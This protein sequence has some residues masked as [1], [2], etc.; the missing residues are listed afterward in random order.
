MYASRSILAQTRLEQKADLTNF[1]TQAG[2]I[3]QEGSGFFSYQGLG[4]MALHHLEERLHQAMRAAGVVQWKMC[5]LQQQ[6]HW[7]KTGRDTQYGEELMSVRLRSGHTMRLTATAEEQVVASVLHHLKG[8]HNDFHLYQLGTK[9]RDEI[10]ARGGLLRGREFRMLDA[11]HFAQDE[12]MMMMRNSHM[13]DELVLF[14]QSLGCNVRVVDAECGEIGGLMSQEIQVATDLADDGW[15]EVGHC[16]ALGQQYS[17]AFGLTTSSGQHAWMSC[18]GL[19]TSRLLAV[20]L[21][22]RR[23]GVQLVGDEQFSVMDDV[24]LAIGKEEETHERAKTVYEHLKKKGR[25]VVF[26][27]R[28]VRAGQQLTSSESLGAKT[29]FVLSDRLGENAVE[30]ERLSDGSKKNV[31]L[32]EW[33]RE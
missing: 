30:I 17:Q 24:V 15:L 26:D 7:D 5:H 10:R 23:R 1:L 18:Q 16:F 12:E 11:Y 32:D 2:F 29:R 28:H 19:G 33:L 14:V 4:M 20:V 3:A 9:W 6:D 13:R 21:N 8:R 27:D 31:A 22:A 25:R